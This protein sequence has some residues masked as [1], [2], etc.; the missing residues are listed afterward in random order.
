MQCFFN[1][2]K[3]IGTEASLY[4]QLY[5]RDVGM[6]SR[7]FRINPLTSRLTMRKKEKCL[8][9][10][11]F[12]VF[13]TICCGALFFVPELRDT[14]LSN[15]ALVWS[16]PTTVTINKHGPED[17]AGQ[18]PRPSEAKCKNMILQDLLP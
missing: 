14:Y 4:S 11:V 17:I 1:S 16:P 12:L 9:C 5:S 13:M 10:M 8:L 18:L 2:S 15:Y 6:A 3:P 7:L